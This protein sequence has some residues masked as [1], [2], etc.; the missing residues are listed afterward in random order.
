[1][2]K[3]LKIAVPDDFD[4]DTDK[5]AFELVGT[6]RADSNSELR[7]TYTVDI[8]QP[9]YTQVLDHGYIGL[10]DFMGDDDA[11]VEA[12]RTSYGKGTTR[13]STDAGL[14]RYLMRHRH[15]TP[16]EMLEF[17]FHVKAPLF[18]FRQWHRH[19]TANINEYSARYSELDGDM[20]VPA[21]EH[22]APQSKD[23]KQGRGGVMSDRN[24]EAV[25][26]AI[27]QAN[28]DAYQNYQYLLGKTRS[29]S[30][31]LNHCRLQ[32]ENAALEAM[33]ERR[34]MDPEW[35]PTPDEMDAI[36]DE[37]FTASDLMFTD[38]EFVEDQ[39]L[40]RELARM[41]MPVNV[42]SQMYW[43]C[44]LHNIFRFIGLRSDPHAQYEIRAY[45]DA[46]LELIRP[47]AP[48]C[49]A[50]FLDYEANGARFS[51]NEIDVIRALVNDANSSVITE[52]AV[53]M[54]RERGSSDRE[55]DEF[56]KK[57]TAR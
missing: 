22:I 43:K 28:R 2:T 5:F 7:R 37:Y 25:R 32:C 52:L 45:S 3:Y 38:S 39:G 34:A 14:I 23:N 36:I 9:K 51:A 42:Y 49:T 6:T 21:P 15:T 19:R 20:Y 29:P 55:I 11:V 44:D 35:K 13:K 4:L 10:K 17:K 16:F 54:M 27:E 46:M 8:W 53:T 57:I 31:S 30:D 33:R 48:L 56:L 47:L 40:A 1:M 41:V 50:A 18:V 12:A 24:K 26:V